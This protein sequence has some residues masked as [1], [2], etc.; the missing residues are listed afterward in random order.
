MDILETLGST[1]GLG[2][3]A[4]IRL[5]LTVFVLG[6]AS[7]FGWLDWSPM[8]A[9]LKILAHPA[10]LITSGAM[11]LVEFISDKVPWF[12]SM[13]DS[14][15]TFVRPIGAMLL[16]GVALGPMDSGAKLALALVTGGVAL[17]SHSSKA[18]TRLAV[19][20]SP[21]P[22]S[23][24]ALSFAGDLAVPAG[25]WFVMHYPEV[26][27]ALL[28]AFLVLF[29]WLAPKI[30]RLLKLEFLALRGL[31]N[32]LVGS[33]R[34][35]PGGRLELPP[36]LSPNTASLFYMLAEKMDPMPDSWR[37]QVRSRLKLDRVPDAL[38]CA[39][40]NGGVKHLRNSVGYLMVAGNDM[41]FVTRRG[42]RFRS[43]SI[44][45][46]EVEEV[47][48]EK[49][50]LLDTLTIRANDRVHEF[51]V[52]KVPPRAAVSAGIVYGARA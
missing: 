30:Y 27:L 2:F 17:T 25:A 40:S 24:V 18:A 41:V 50:L 39:A 37:E 28:T 45:L 5:Y 42:F 33:E 47:R 15:H 52:F 38:L 6:V 48:W 36:G 13:W 3:L 14:V 21:E 34:S 19:N 20:H 31:W 44:A 35:G 8:A 29:A 16:A 4:G 49:G 10:V 46:G 12:D 7:Y 22:M 43:Y 32:R 23:N 1:L 11:T 51:E 26:A 9:Q